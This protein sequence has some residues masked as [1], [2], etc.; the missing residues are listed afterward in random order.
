MG[1][2]S[3][4]RDDLANLPTYLNLF[5]KVRDLFGLFFGSLCLGLLQQLGRLGLEFSKCFFLID[6]SLTYGE[7]AFLLLLLLLP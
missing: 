2:V 5:L 3:A 7:Y 1:A 6:E 4:V